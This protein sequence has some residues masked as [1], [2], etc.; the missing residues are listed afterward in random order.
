MASNPAIEPKTRKE[1]QKQSVAR[2][3][4]MTTFIPNRTKRKAPVVSIDIDCDEAVNSMMKAKRGSQTCSK[5]GS[6]DGV[7]SGTEAPDSQCDWC[8]RL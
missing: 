5:C 1:R 4:S 6:V 3:T 8:Q 7:Y 2:A